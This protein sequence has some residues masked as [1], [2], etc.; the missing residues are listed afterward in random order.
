MPLIHN[1]RKALNSTDLQTLQEMLHG[2]LQSIVTGLTNL[3]KLSGPNSAADFDPAIKVFQKGL[4]ELPDKFKAAQKNKKS[5]TATEFIQEMY[6]NLA[7]KVVATLNPDG[8]GYDD[9]NSFLATQMGGSVFS[10]KLLDFPPEE[11]DTEAGYHDSADGLKLADEP[12]EG[13]EE[14]AEYKPESGRI[15]ALYEGRAGNSNTLRDEWLQQL[16]KDVEATKNN[17]D[18]QAY[19]K[20]L[21]DLEKA[22]K[23]PFGL[24]AAAEYARIRSSEM[25]AKDEIGLADVWETFSN[26]NRMA[27]PNDP[28]G[29]TLRGQGITAG[30]LKGP[31]VMAVPQQTYQTMQ[32]IAEHM[33]TIKQTQDPA[34][35]KTR[36][37]QLAAYAYQMTL[38][39]HVFS[40]G[41]GRTCRM[42]AD[43][44]LQSFGLPPHIPSKEEGKISKTIGTGKMDF[45]KGAEVFLK[46]VQESDLELKKDPELVKERLISKQAEKKQPEKKQPNKEKNR[47]RLSAIYEVS[48]DTVDLLGD[49]KRQAAHAKGN[50][51][52]SQEYKNFLGA[53]N[54]SHLLAKEIQQKRDTAGFDLK[55][56]EAAYAASIRKL[57]K[58]AS[59]YTDYKL[60]DHTE[61]RQQEPE[62]KKLNDKDREKLNLMKN[63]T[64]NKLLTKEK[65]APAEGIAQRQ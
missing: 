2:N 61:N 56:A 35:R 28:E 14:I 3:G 36:A 9:L 10:T 27:R 17:V 7:E 24:H 41:N 23:A 55:K 16:E 4:E 29:G 19:N 8:E 48:D 1:S 65:E 18:K 51:R 22:K 54:Q 46:G 57:F 59:D 44:I 31:N 53:V 25:M 21:E 63:L 64:E 34:L 32:T 15:I 45:N 47:L 39:Q 5:Q 30:E 42:F 50:F 26:L 20:A 43:S 60:K 58:T 49:L 52:D 11:R 33:N 62:K 40:D 38:S 37:I 12:M 6:D 13:I